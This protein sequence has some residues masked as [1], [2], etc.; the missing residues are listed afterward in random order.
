MGGCTIRMR[1][2]IARAYDVRSIFT[3]LALAVVYL[4]AGQLGSRFAIVHGV[5]SP[6]W[7]ASGLGVAALWMLGVSRWPGLFLGAYLAN[8]LSGASPLA[9]L[10]F[11]AGNTLEA[12]LAVLLL[13]RLGFSEALERVQDVVALIVGAGMGCTLVSALPGS[14]GFV[15]LGL[16]PVSGF[17]ETAW[18]WWG[19][20]A[21]GIVVVTPVLL[22]L[23][24][25]RPIERRMEA[26]ALGGCALLVC[27]EVFGGGLL[28]SS[29]PYPY[30]ESFLF[31]PV[32][33]WAA[34]RFGARGAAFTTLLIT[35]L[36]VWAT[37]SR[38]G[39]FAAGPL[40]RGL[41]VVQLF[42]A[43][44]ATTGLLLAAVS[45]GRREATQRLELLATAVR[46]LSEGVVISELSPMGP[47]VVFANDAFCAMVGMG[48]V[49]LLAGSPRS[50][51]GEMDPETH[52]RLDAALREGGPFRGQV[53]LK[54]RDGTRVHS[55]MQL[56]PMRGSQG[57][58]THFVCSYRDVTATQELRSRLLAS[59]RVAAVGML[60]AGV[61]H[62][63]QNPLAYLELN[64][65][66]AERRLRRGDARVEEVLHH[67]RDAHEGAE[68]IRLIVQDLRTFSREG[69]EE[70]KPLDLR[71]VAAPALRM[72]RHVLHN[73]AR[74]VEEHGTI[75]RVMGSE[76][77]L[78]QVLLNL[79]VNAV[80]AVPPGAPER[81]TVRISTRTAPD[82][83]AQVEISDTGR[84]ILPEVLPHIFK[85]FFTTKPLEEGTG[86]G[87]SICQ[88][89]IQAHGGEILV[90]SEPGQGAVFTVL[91]PAASEEALSAA[92][93]PREK[94][95]SAAAH[96]GQA[97]R[98][99]ILIVDDEPRMAQ[100]LRMLLEPAHDVVA[101]TRGSEAL[102][103][104]SSGQRFDLVVCDLQMPGTTGMEVY[105]R[106]SEQAP[107]LAQRL[108]F[109]SGGAYTPAASAF[110][111]S[112][113]NRVLEKPVR[114]DVFL[115]TIDAA[116]A[117]RASPSGL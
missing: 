9:S 80:Q 37:V 88:Q 2:R 89:I 104:V 3:M 97:R 56:S 57:R 52:Q 60:A 33:V 39:P 40:D 85:P 113:P 16:L 72:V 6:V 58:V 61:G 66:A 115:A 46:G 69:G 95:E 110:I 31:F 27:A 83:R 76:A 42:I 5:V 8:L 53:L 11:S 64:L 1:E 22:F 67:L 45:A 23:R 111:R 7:P 49:E 30:I 54:H 73:R 62:E 35:V 34:L 19:G 78:G 47:Q 55:E 44:N 50:F 109:M 96:S 68:R 112:V 25:L 94:E 90:R 92:P 38:L 99:R 71:E 14:A 18:V 70:R 108:V 86:L 81:N 48:P 79:L 36:S 106:L 63:I 17:V 12:V 114:P 93:L 21:M 20:D 41:L 75:P 116:L 59:E 74:L 28:G 43:I 91:L 51:A 65:D 84:G 10:G 24:R 32:A 77:R 102:E 100:S 13:R 103:M 87:L 117:P 29:M 15:M 107:E 82:G 101:T 26:V 98:G 4:G 105:A